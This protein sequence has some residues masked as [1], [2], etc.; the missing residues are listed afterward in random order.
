LAQLLL[1]ADATVTIAHSRTRDLA[2]E[3]RRAEI[4]V[5]AAGRP[6]L[7]RGDW[8]A[9][10]AVVIDVGVNRVAAAGGPRLVGDV[11]TEEAL[12]VAA[13][14]TPVPGGVGPM[15]VACLLENTVIA[16]RAQTEA[17]GA[18]AGPVGAHAQ[19]TADS[20]SGSFKV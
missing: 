20:D 16:A 8:L 19:A 5:A 10:G 17:A 6:G 3:C 2:A 7:V 15:T 14:V 1:L 11:V 18:A 9:P 4:V 13:A 12:G